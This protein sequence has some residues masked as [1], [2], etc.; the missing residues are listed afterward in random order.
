[1]SVK[2]TRKCNV[3]KKDLFKIVPSDNILGL[4]FCKTI[5]ITPF[6]L[7]ENKYWCKE[8]YKKHL[9]TKGA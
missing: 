8:C 6:L 3:C 1:M 9:E 2:N 4:T 7:R 5:E